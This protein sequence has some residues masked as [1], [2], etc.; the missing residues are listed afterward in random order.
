[1]ERATTLFD[2]D[3]QAR[4]EA[5]KQMTAEHEKQEQQLK[6][7]LGEDRYAKYTDYS[8]TAGDRMLLNQF[9]GANSVTEDQTRLL[10]DAIKEERRS[11]IAEAGEPEAGNRQARELQALASEEELNKLVQLQERVNGRVLERA[12]IILAPEQIDA[13]GKFQA[14]QIEM[15]RMSMNMARTMFGG[16]KAEG[17][18]PP[19]AAKP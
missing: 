13:F 17:G 5:V 19:S 6:D 2:N 18:T 16:G 14:S 15:Q 8:Q 10:L 7:F 11:A 3:A 1:M 12:K 9:T 4:E